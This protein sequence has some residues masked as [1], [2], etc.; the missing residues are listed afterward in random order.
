MQ[1]VRLGRSGLS[2]PRICLGT[3]NFGVGQVAK[4]AATKIMARALDL[5]IDMI[6]TSDLYTGGES[7]KIIGEFVK[8]RREDVILT[9]KVGKEADSYPDTPPNRAGCSRKNIIY[10]LE[11]SLEKLQ[12]DYIDL[13]YIHKYDS[14]VP[15]EETMRTLDSLVK[16]GKIRY[17]ACSNYNAEQI[18]ES[19]QI[20]EKLG[21]ENYIAVQNS[22]NLFDREMERRV[23]PYCLAYGLGTLAYSPLF[24]GFLAG[25]YERDAPPP[26]GSRATYKPPGWLKR[27]GTEENFRELDKIKSVARSAGLTLS[28]LALSWVLREGRASCAI[29]GAS[30]ANQLDEPVRATETKLA[31]EVVSQ[32]EELTSSQ[33]ART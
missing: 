11:Q 16:Q 26:A 33:A 21:L 2:V 32:L 13:Y 23:I 15:L 5:G 25:R 17:I 1:R 24:G 31:P 18:A 20:A 4:E 9:T 8:G 29:V 19:R 3:N 28:V 12:T 6:D 22:Y 30:D 7:E 14:A 27:Y 10:R